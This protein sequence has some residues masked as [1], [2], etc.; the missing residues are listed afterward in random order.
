MAS[1]G[2]GGGMMKEKRGRSGGGAEDRLDETLKL[3]HLQVSAT[4]AV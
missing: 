2:G 4:G 3:R 1:E